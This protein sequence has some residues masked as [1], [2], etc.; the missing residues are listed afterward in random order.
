MTYGV[1]KD[2]CVE[3]FD[4]AL[5]LNPTSAIARTEYAN[6]LFTLF[7][8]AKVKDAEKLYAEAAAC[9]PMDAMECLDIEA[10]KAELE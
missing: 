3:N 5:K 1:S 2:A 9:E 6:A 8:K 7:G 10:A 4:K